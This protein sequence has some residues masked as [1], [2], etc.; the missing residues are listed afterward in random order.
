[1]ISTQVNAN[2]R[3]DGSWKTESMR[4]WGI[5]SH[6]HVTAPTH[7]RARAHTHTHT[8]THAQKRGGK[9]NKKTSKRPGPMGLTRGGWTVECREDPWIPDDGLDSGLECGRTLWLITSG[10]LHTNY[11]GE[12]NGPWTGQGLRTGLDWT[13]LDHGLWT[14]TWAGLTIKLLSC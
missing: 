5:N 10:G 11:T 3:W 6:K 14:R 1:M 7:T 8:H 9:Q 12:K 13:G 4:K 2:H